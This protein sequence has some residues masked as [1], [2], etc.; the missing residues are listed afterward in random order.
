MS[1]NLE[2]GA[3]W[4][5]QQGWR[6]ELHRTERAGSTEKHDAKYIARSTTCSCLGTTS[7]VSVGL[8]CFFVPPVLLWG[9]ALLP[10]R[11]NSSARTS[12]EV[13]RNSGVICI[14]CAGP[15]LGAWQRK[16]SK[17]QAIESAQ[18]ENVTL[19]G[20]GDGLTTRLEYLVNVQLWT[21]KAVLV[22]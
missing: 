6:T 1:K 17:Q 2:T 5:W 22:I 11:K 20:R 8:C 21:R 18:V 12:F 19:D 13:R 15:M 3:F 7:Y 4:W 14:F 9:N 16:T 10:V